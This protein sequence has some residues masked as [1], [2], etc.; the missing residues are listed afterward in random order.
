MIH[1]GACARTCL[2]SRYPYVDLVVHDY[3]DVIQAGFEERFAIMDQLALAMFSG[4]GN[5][6]SSSAL[7]AGSDQDDDDCTIM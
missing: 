2:A 4:N 5:T 3:E 6:T 1:A 7:E